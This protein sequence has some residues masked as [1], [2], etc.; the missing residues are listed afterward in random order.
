MR[1]TDKVKN[2][3]IGAS[4]FIIF[5]LILI[6]L[7]RLQKEGD[8]MDVWRVEGQVV[9]KETVV[10]EN[11]ENGTEEVYLIKIY[12]LDSEDDAV[13]TF[14]M[15]DRALEGNIAA[16][17]AYKEIKTGRA[18]RFK[19]GW[20]DKKVMNR[21]GYYPSIYGAASLVEF[22]LSVSAEES[23]AKAEEGEEAKD[24]AQT[25]NTGRKEDISEGRVS[26]EAS[27]TTEASRTTETPQTTE[28]AETR[29]ASENTRADRGETS[30]APDG[31][32]S[33]SR[34]EIGGIKIEPVEE[35]VD[36]KLLES[37]EERV[38]AELEESIR[39]DLEES[40]RAELEESFEA[41]K[42]SLREEV[43]QLFGSGTRN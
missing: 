8:K 24:G 32:E 2:I 9:E 7:S 18:Y 15:T 27:Q 19:V 36:E 14:E 41:E 10:R 25:G 43:E 16:K 33:P 6:L 5:V 13:H 4:A 1:D 21:A 17:D 40:I 30:A 35:T 29:E 34:L 42:D 38:K 20:R 22:N 39:A 28:E 31:A 11:E 3:I 37:V 26:D 23:L 12:S